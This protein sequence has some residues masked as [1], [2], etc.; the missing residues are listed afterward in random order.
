M[1]EL[2]FPK[3]NLN[4]S[5]DYMKISLIHTPLRNPTGGERQILKLAIELQKKGHDVELFTNEVDYDRCFPDLLSQV[6]IRI[7]PYPVNIPYIRYFFGM[8]KIG[9]L[10]SKENPDI[11]NNHNYPTEWAVYFANKYCK[12]PSVWMC[13]EPPFWFFQ[14]EARKGIKK[15]Q[16]PVY[17]IFDKKTVKSIDKILVLSNLMGNIVKKT[18][19]RDYTVIRSGVDIE[20][21]EGISGKKFREKYGLKNENIILQVGSI[22]YYKQQ[23]C[24]IKSLA[25]LVKNGYDDIKLIFIGVETKKY[26]EKLINMINRYNLEDKVL[27]L[28]AV[29]DDTLKQAYAACDVFVFPSSQSWS[30]VTVEAMASKKPVIVSNECGVSEI[31]DHGENG[32]VIKHSDYNALAKYIKALIDDTNYKKEIGKNAY[33]FI[34]ENMSWKKYGENMERIF[35]RVLLNSRK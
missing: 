34:K 2:K 26:K 24:S 10:V 8:L 21:F 3:Y 17:E 16:W 35:E 23:E 13:N 30:L 14:E 18:Y 1:D 28:G 11:I 20:D 32:F 12:I 7:V 6:N 27:F 15:V 4:I 25:H 9:K 19:G 33:K 5:R 22:V 31:I 29:S